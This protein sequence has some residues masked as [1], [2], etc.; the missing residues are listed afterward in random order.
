MV[1]DVCTGRAKNNDFRVGGGI[2]AG[3]IAVPALGDDLAVVDDDGAYRNF[4]GGEGTLS[5][6]ESG[7]HEE[8]VRGRTVVGRRRSSVVGQSA[9]GILN[10]RCPS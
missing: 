2:V 6:A 4:S 9:S 7:F 1:T 5:G 3:E 10:C 8:F